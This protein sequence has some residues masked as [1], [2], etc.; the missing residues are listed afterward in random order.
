[1]AGD[2]RN[3]SKPIDA[4]LMIPTGEKGISQREPGTCGKIGYR[5]A[6]SGERNDLRGAHQCATIVLIPADRGVK[7]TRGA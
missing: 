3:V 6:D 2:Q 5:G 7:P 1:M 4:E